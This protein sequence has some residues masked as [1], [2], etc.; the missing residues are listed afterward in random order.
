M[1]HADGMPVGKR[2]EFHFLVADAA[3]AG[4]QDGVPQGAEVSRDLQTSTFSSVRLLLPQAG[5]SEAERCLGK[6]DP[7]SGKAPTRSLRLLCFGCTGFTVFLLHVKRRRRARRSGASRDETPRRARH[8]ASGPTGSR[9]PSSTR[10]AWRSKSA[11]WSATSRALLSPTGEVLTCKYYGL[12]T[13]RVPTICITTLPSVTG[14]R[15][16]GPAAQS[17]QG[18]VASF[19]YRRG[20]GWGAC[21]LSIIRCRLARSHQSA[22]ITC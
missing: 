8:S 2:T 7:A 6:K 13:L 21:P 9:R 5:E 15:F 17:R 18:G 3:G 10:P 4:A 16:A 22:E 11:R 20:G 19:C 14:V 12:Y 1:Q